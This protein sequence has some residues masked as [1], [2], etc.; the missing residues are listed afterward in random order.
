MLSRLV[1][2]LVAILMVGCARAPIA[3]S[4]AEAPLKVICYNIRIGAGP[5][6]PFGSDAAKENLAAIA[7]FINESEPDIVLLQE[8]DRNTAR[9]KGMDELQ[10][11]AEATNMNPAWGKAME[12]TGGEYG[13]AILSRHPIRDV[14]VHPLFRPDYSKTNPEWPA[15]YAEQRVALTLVTDTPDGPVQ[16]L[17]AHLGITEDQR[18]RQ[19]AQMA[20]II[21]SMDPAVATVAGGDFNAKPDEA[22]LAALRGVLVDG[23]SLFPP[24]PTFSTVDPN[25]TIDYIFASSQLTMTSLTVPDVRHSDHLP[26]VAVMER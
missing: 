18:A 15:W 1:L 14:R 20:E 5:E 11:L 22:G 16:V 25:R 24:V 10:M 6:G 8:V 26:V 21:E 19:F 9:V 23:W 3:E 2:M 7:T 4:R 13:I 12:N 17:N